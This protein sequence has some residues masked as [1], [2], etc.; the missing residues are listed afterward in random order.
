M[1]AVPYG[2]PVGANGVPIAVRPDQLRMAIIDKALD[3]RVEAY[4]A[5]LPKRG[6]VGWEYA[7]QIRRDSPLIE[8]ARTAL[9]M[10]VKQM[11]DLFKLAATLN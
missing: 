9:S 6:K 4:I 1:S 5:A 11:D 2:P 3:G 10:T 7:V 8:E